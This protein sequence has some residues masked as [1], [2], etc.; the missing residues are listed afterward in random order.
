MCVYNTYIYIYILYVYYTSCTTIP[1]TRLFEPCMIFLYDLVRWPCTTS[2]YDNLVRQF[3]TQL[4]TIA[5]AV[6]LVQVA[7]GIQRASLGSLFVRSL[8]RPLVRACSSSRCPSALPGQFLH[9]QE[10]QCSVNSKL[11][12]TACATMTSVAVQGDFDNIVRGVCSPLLE[13]AN[14]VQ[15]RFVRSLVRA[16]YDFRNAAE[17]LC[18]KVFGK[19]WTS[20]EQCG[21]TLYDRFRDYSTAA[22]VACTRL[23]RNFRLIFIR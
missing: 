23:V 11:V 2:L 3:S 16:L 18:T 4:C 20:V 5:C 10:V 14:P 6:Q 9:W 13:Q 19:A 8:V 21:G 17:W 15:R 12:R 7:S 1:C 22:E